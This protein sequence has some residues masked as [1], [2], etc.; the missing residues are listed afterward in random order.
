[1]DA[2]VEGV[3]EGVGGGEGGEVGEHDFAHLYGVDHGLIEDALIFDLSADEDEEAGSGEDGVVEIEA[4]E[5]EGDSDDLAE[6]G[7]GAGWPG[8]LPGSG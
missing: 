7:E 3:G 8:W 6:A 2:A 4:D 1:M 5:D